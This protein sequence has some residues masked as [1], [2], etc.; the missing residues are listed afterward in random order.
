[1]DRVVV[2]TV[3]A[4]SVLAAVMPS[5]AGTTIPGWVPA[6]NR[7]VLEHVFGGARPVQTDYISYPHKL[8]VV[9]VFSRVVV[10]GACSA[11]SNAHLPRGRVIRFTFDRRTH[12]GTGALEFC[13]AKGMVPAR[14]LCLRH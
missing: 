4:V 13:E 12:R 5:A 11:P 6:A 2:I 10:C 9:F 7:L 3:V 1:M 8:A 14:A